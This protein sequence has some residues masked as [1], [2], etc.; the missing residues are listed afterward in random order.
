MAAQV[1]MLDKLL[2]KR[3]S[4][5]AGMGLARGPRLWAFDLCLSASGSDTYDPFHI[6]AWIS[7]RQS[8]DKMVVP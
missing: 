2:D 6:A 8:V 4:W 5:D 3:R 1:E 7:F